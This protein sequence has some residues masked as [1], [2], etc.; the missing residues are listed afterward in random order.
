LSMRLIAASCLAVFAS[1]SVATAGS[2]DV[3]QPTVRAA[4]A[5]IK[6]PEPGS[7]EATA[8]VT[9]D[10][11]TMYDVFVVGVQ[12]DVAAI[13]IRDSPKGAAASVAVHEVPVP[14]FGRLEMSPQAVHLRLKE[15]KKPLVAGQ[16]VQLVV[17]TDGG[18]QLSIAA[19]VK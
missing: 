2:V 13:E 19:T 15:L 16:I 7:A 3:F 10:N 1:V 18:E 14:A 8:F 4:E 11:G 12:T 9:I 17:H 6:A 5:W